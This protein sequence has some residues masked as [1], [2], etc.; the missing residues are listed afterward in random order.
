MPLDSACRELDEIAQL[1][2]REHELIRCM[3]AHGE[4]PCEGDESR[5]YAGGISQLALML[6]PLLLT[7]LESET[8]A[9]LVA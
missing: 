1:L 7:A 9:A 2:I 6:Q 5:A 8:A 4:P 3:R